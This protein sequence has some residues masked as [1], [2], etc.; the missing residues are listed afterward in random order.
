MDDKI[1]VAGN[2]Q[3]GQGKGIND[4]EAVFILESDETTTEKLIEKWVG[5]AHL[6]VIPKLNQEELLKEE[7]DFFHGIPEPVEIERKYLIEYPD[8][9]MLEQLSCCKRVEISQTYIKYGKKDKFRVRRRAVDGDEVFIKT[10]KKKID[11]IKRIEI[12]E[13]ISRDEYE[14]ILADRDKVICSISKDRYCFVY[15]RQYFE[16]DVFPFWKDKAMMEIELK[17]EDDKFILPDF[18][19]IIREVTE[20]AEFT[21]FALAKAQKSLY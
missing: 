18:V 3:D 2:L 12:E 15:K 1:L 13:Y 6:R 8:I 21:N 9:E 17:S 4:Y 7:I 19:N 11:K 16:L 5:N 20:E 14:T 10:Y